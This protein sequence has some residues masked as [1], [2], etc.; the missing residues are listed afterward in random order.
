MSSKYFR[1]LCYTILVSALTLCF[2]SC[3]SKNEQLGQDYLATNQKYDVYSSEFDI[4]DIEMQTPDS[5]SAYSLYK[6][7]FGAVRDETFGLTT[8][9]CAFTLVPLNDTLD[10][11][12]PGTRQFKNFHFSAVNDS[13]SCSNPRQANILQN[14]NVYELKEAIN[15]KASYPK[16]KIG[17]TRLTDGV[18]VY[19][20]KDS[21]SFNFS[22]AFGEKYMNILQSDLDSISHYTKKFPGIFISTDAPMGNGGR[23]NMFRLP[24]D[25]ANYSIYGSYAKLTF[26]AEYDK[27][28][29]I[30]TTFYF[31]LGPLKISGF[32]GTKTTSPTTHPQLAYNMSDSENTILKGKATDKV[33]FEGGQGVKPVIKASGLRKKAIEIISKYG[34][35]SKIVISKASIVLPFVFPD[36][37]KDMAYYPTT[38]SPTCR[39]VKDKSIK[40][41]GITD[42]SVKDENKGAINRSLCNYA[43]DLTHHFQE[44]LKVKDMAKIENYDIWLLAMAT[45]T[46]SNRQAASNANRNN[47]AMLQNMMYNNYYNNIYNGY[48]GYGGYGY[49]GYGSYGNYYNNY[50]NYAYLQQMYS[51]SRVSATKK[52]SMMDSHRFYR[53]ILQGPTSAKDKPKCKIVFAV[54]K[55]K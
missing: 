40:Y 38:L 17:T 50:M 24:I 48:G 53:A 34:D 54:P 16:L 7:A 41:A 42:S 31:Q 49:G 21:L 43:P 13:I 18:P 35:P 15:F 28:G 32:R 47:N 1:K 44:I 22:K 26:S 27:R 52:I 8:R 2:S 5:L 11:G 9:A 46:V 36:N 25:I 39:I 51:S 33:Y 12:K 55:D 19:N 23:I 14:V 6:F 4:D 20:G 29:R 10:F 3:I 30:D 45:E 37:Y